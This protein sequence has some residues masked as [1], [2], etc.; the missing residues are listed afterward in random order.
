MRGISEAYKQ[1]QHELIQVAE[2]VGI[3]VDNGWILPPYQPLRL[4]NFAVT[5]V[6]KIFL[7]RVQ[8]L[9]EHG[10]NMLSIMEKFPQIICTLGE[11]TSTLFVHNYLGVKTRL[12]EDWEK[13]LCN[14][15]FARLDKV[16][17]MEVFWSVIE[18][19]QKELREY[20]ARALVDSFLSRIGS[21]DYMEVFWQV[22]EELQEKLG[23]EHWARP[24][25]GCFLSRIESQAYMKTFW[26]VI[27]EL[28]EKLGEYWARPLHNPFLS[29]I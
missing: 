14:A 1:R 27:E 24:L 13:P 2:E 28:Q 19:L 3:P 25:Q 11:E 18:K 29:R 23:K 7:Q 16:A 4:L 10:I 5:R 20:W 6:R 21:T 26:L 15:L 8:K 22:I 17:C 9:K 12:K